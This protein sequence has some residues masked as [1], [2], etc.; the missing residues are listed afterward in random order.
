MKTRPPAREGTPQ[1]PSHF[2]GPDPMDT[3]AALDGIP[4]VRYLEDGEE[5]APLIDALLQKIHADLRG[6]TGGTA[7]IFFDHMGKKITVESRAPAPEGTVVFRAAITLCI[8]PLAPRGEGRH[9]SVVPRIVAGTLL[10]KDGLA[11]IAKGAEEQFGD[12][13]QQIQDRLNALTL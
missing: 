10:W 13:L 2:G 8:Q 1:P 7:K 3:A 5:P 6:W 12:Y 11:W 9:L 4:W